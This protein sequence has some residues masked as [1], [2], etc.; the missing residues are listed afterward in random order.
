MRETRHELLIEAEALIRRRGYS[1]FSFSDLAECVGIRKASIHH[2]FRTKADLAAALFT[3]YDKRY[4]ERLSE[5]AAASTDGVSRIEAY[6]ELYLEGAEEGFSCLCA[7][8]AM[9]ADQFPEALSTDI[10]FFFSKHITWLQSVLIE[11]QKNNTICT[12]IDPGASARMIVAALQGALMMQ[13]TLPDSRG[14][15][16]V[17]ESLKLGLVRALDP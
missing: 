13:R 15:R 14:F 12:R 3:S 16:M 7:V 17:V 5:I 4:D 9:D 8:L 6:A 10:A 2:H 11:G 1:R